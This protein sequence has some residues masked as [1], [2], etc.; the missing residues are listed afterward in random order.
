MTTTNRCFVVEIGSSAGDQQYSSE[1]RSGRRK[2]IPGTGNAKNTGFGAIIHIPLLGDF[3]K[4]II[5]IHLPT[6]RLKILSNRSNQ[7]QAVFFCIKR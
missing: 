4:H 5:H 6:L 2:D 1:F 3:M 7:A